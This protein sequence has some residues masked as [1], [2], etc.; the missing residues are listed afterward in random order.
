MIKNHG[1]CEITF[2]I[3]G[4]QNVIHSLSTA[5]AVIQQQLCNSEIMISPAFYPTKFLSPGKTL[6]FLAWASK[7]VKRSPGVKPYFRFGAKKICKS[8]LAL[9]ALIVRFTKPAYNRQVKKSQKIGLYQFLRHIFSWI[10]EPA[11]YYL[12]SCVL[13]SN[14]VGWVCN[15]CNQ[16]ESI[17]SACCA[18][19]RPK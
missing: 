12:F 2:K 13:R 10:F 4:L 6:H 11:N 1:K 9:S 14:Q 7:A 19:A 15:Y 18:K 17:N 3:M 16:T 5:P 8:A